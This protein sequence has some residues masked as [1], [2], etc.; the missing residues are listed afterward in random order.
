[1]LTVG[2]VISILVQVALP[3]ALGYYLIRRYGSEWKIF[4]VGALAYLLAQVVQSPVFQTVAGTDFYKTILTDW[5]P[6]IV[7]ILF[8]LVSSLLEN[9]ARFGGFWLI[10]ERAKAWGSSLVMGAGHGGVE[11]LLVGFQFLVNFIFAI[12]I[13]TSGTGSLQISPEE[14]AALGRQVEAF[15]A[16]PW[17]LPL[18]SALQRLSALSLQL[19]L[20][21]MMWIAVSRRMW[22]YAVAA[23]LWHA[24]LSGV[25]AAISYA[26]PNMWNSLLLVGVLLVNSAL[27]VLLYRKAKETGPMEAPI[28]TEKVRGLKFLEKERQEPETP[29][30]SP[31]DYKEIIE[32]KRAKQRQ[33]QDGDQKDE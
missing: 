14:A 31:T 25:A 19:V 26:M 22:I 24:A 8:S 1:M 30:Q 9:A 3:I 18:A 32:A 7:I 5:S 13:T 2:F 17:Y 12:S 15:W 23:V 11:S 27:I 6:T 29:K 4:G 20:S 21:V 16:L 10:R 28:S 33:M